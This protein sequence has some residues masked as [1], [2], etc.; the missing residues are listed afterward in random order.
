MKRVYLR[1]QARMHYRGHT[2]ITNV[3]S[4]LFPAMTSAVSDSNC[5]TPC[6]CQVA[7]QE[8]LCKIGKES[9]NYQS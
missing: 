3:L 1:K 8:Q 7:L 9:R 6:I 2:L 5:C 4:A